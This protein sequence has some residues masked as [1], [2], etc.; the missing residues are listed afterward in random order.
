MPH[1]LRLPVGLILEI[2]Y[3]YKVKGEDDPVCKKSEE[4]VERFAACTGFSGF[5]VNWFPIR[6]SVLRGSSL[7]DLTQAYF[8]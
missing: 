8:S 5:L 3:G 4:W 6:E 2:S 1:S 7:V